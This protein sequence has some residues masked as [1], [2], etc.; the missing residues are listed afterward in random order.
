MFIN[1]FTY[2]MK[3][4]YSPSPIPEKE[5]LLP[6]NI[7]EACGQT[8][9]RFGNKTKIAVAILGTAAVGALALSSSSQDIS[10]SPAMKKSS[11]GSKL[12]EQ[13]KASK[14]AASKTR[15]SDMDDDEINNLFE[16]FM[17]DFSKPYIKDS[18]S[19]ASRFATFKVRYI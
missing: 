4:K 8:T 3:W 12:V 9:P 13:A 17:S 16:N 18:K 15:Y 7:Q 11:K 14:T 2:V 19:R 10:S 6:E 1:S 5:L